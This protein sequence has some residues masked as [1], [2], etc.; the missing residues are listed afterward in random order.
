MDVD[1]RK[2][3]N[4]QNQTLDATRTEQGWISDEMGTDV[5][6]KKDEYQLKWQRINIE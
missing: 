6:L 2:E 3:P 1:H 5:G 4:R